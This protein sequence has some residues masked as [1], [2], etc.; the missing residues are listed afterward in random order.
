MCRTDLKEKR[1]FKKNTGGYGMR[2][3]NS[4]R[5]LTSAFS[6]SWTIDVKF[7]PLLLFQSPSLFPYPLFSVHVLPLS[8]SNSSLAFPTRTFFSSS[9]LNQDEKKVNPWFLSMLSFA[10][11][12]P[13]QFFPILA[14]SIVLLCL[15]ASLQLLNGPHVFSWPI[16]GLSSSFIFL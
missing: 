1:Y 2:N 14:H 12:F 8:P 10:F 15:S 5:P 7:D 11:V 4:W 9:S 6:F 3:L 13:S 16:F